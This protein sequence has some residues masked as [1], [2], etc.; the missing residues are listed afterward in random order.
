MTAKK[1]RGRPAKM[2]P[3]TLQDDELPPLPKLKRSRIQYVKEYSVSRIAPQQLERRIND[4]LGD[5]SKGH[6]E[7]KSI[8]PIEMDG[9][10]EATIHSGHETPRVL[11]VYERDERRTDPSRTGGGTNGQPHR[12]ATDAAKVKLSGH[13]SRK[14]AGSTRKEGVSTYAH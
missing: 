2:Q 6:P 13:Q 9:Q 1:R 8:Y 7:V 3:Q 5:R 4:E 10:I 12:R 14:R 11:V